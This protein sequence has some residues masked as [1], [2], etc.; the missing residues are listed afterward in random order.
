[1][2]GLK[3]SPLTEQ[4]PEYNLQE[5]ILRKL[6]KDDIDDMLQYLTD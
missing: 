1:M 2:G 6:N 4:F 3:I 5:I